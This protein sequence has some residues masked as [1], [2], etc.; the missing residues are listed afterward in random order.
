MSAE[1][2][3]ARLLRCYP[4]AWRSR[5]GDEFAALLLAELTERPR[6]IS[7]TLD[8]VCGG[9]LARVRTAGLA[10]P[11]LE[12]ERQLRA[13]LGAL[14]GALAVFAVAGVALWSQLTIGWQ[15]SA[16]ASGATRTGMLL[17]TASVCAITVL[18]LLAVAP[19]AWS[20]GRAVL[21]GESRAFAG[22]ML[23]AAAGTAVLVA[24]SVHFGHG[25]PGTGGHPWGGRGI[26]PG[27]VARIAWAATLWIS[28]YWAHPGALSAFPAGEIGWMVL[29]PV[30]LVAVAV[31]AG[32][33]LRA[34]TLSRRV[35]G[36]EARLGFAAAVAMG[37]FLAGG[38]SWIVSGGA[39][40]RGLF[41]VGA[42]DVAGLVV[43]AAA[44]LVGCRAVQRIG[45]RGVAG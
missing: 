38:G 4:R 7:R 28:A 17:M 3:A 5:Y 6:S 37:V 9:L 16:P 29:A 22:W 27:T 1:R 43:L 15:W 25:W 12:H 36:Y 45:L 26:V 35:L 11:P 40:P 19:I 18:A 23:L 32:R 33:V 31:G 2:R 39:A 34:L 21:A 44:L 42:I 30:A 41:A 13:S 24:G 14:A 20:L 10:G 8:V